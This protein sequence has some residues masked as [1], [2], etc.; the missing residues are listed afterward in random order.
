VRKLEPCPSCGGTD[1][2]VDCFGL[3]GGSVWCNTN[4]CG[5]GYGVK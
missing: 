3:S 2:F 1:I 5:F 4:N